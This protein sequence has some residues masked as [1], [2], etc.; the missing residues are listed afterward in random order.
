MASTPTRHCPNGVLMICQRLRRW[1][2][3]NP[4]FGECAVFAGKTLTLNM[5][6]GQLFLAPNTTVCV[7]TQSSYESIG[8]LFTRMGKGS[9]VG[10][11]RKPP[12]PP[13]LPRPPRPSTHDP[14]S[15]LNF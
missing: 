6:G 14:D 9:R 4:I 15:R 2:N 1:P 5:R 11:S 7:S 3:I 12:R 8:E 10:V 13:R